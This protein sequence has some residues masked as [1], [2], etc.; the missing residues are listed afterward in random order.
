VAID[1]FDNKLELAKQLGA[2]HRIN[3]SQ[4][5]A[6]E[7]VL[8]ILGAGGADVVVDNTGNPR[9]IEAAYRCTGARGRTVLVGVPKKGENVSIYTLPIH[10]EKILH[11]SHGGESLPQYDIPNY[12]KLV[13]AGKLSLKE[14]IGRRYSFDQINEAIAD[15]RS[16][17][18]AGRCMIHMTARG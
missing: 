1:L 4:A 14:I 10:F 3:S 8:K 6:E 5:N 12:V 17:A 16:G 9:V 15:M 2:T 13:Q 11:G 7:E 18:V